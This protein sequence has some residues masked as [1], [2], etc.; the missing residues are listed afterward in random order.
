MSIAPRFGMKGLIHNH[1][2]LK[3]ISR[4]GPNPDIPILFIEIGSRA[5][6]STNRRTIGEC[7]SANGAMAVK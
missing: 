2:I 5:A 4:K 6:S 7:G 3:V 1:F